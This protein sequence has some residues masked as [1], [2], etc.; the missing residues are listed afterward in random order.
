MR[1][2]QRF[3]AFIRAINI[4][5]RR[6]TN[7]QLIEPFVRLGFD[8]VAAYQAAGNVTFRSDD[9]N[10]AQPERLEPAL[11]EAYGLDALTFVRT[12]SEMR[13]IVDACPFTDDDIAKTEGRIQVSFLRGTP[14]DVMIT[15]VLA[16][17]PPDDRI[18]FADHQW[19]WLP[20]NGVSDSQLPVSSVEDIVGPMT[21]RTLGTITRMLDK[22]ER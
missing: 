6:L 19:F 8:D 22:F 9:P 12:L 21:M 18:E 10:A 1:T 16:L 2:C 15:D 5:S 14:D 11:A 20:T 13:A 17:V 3:F 4:G 7:D